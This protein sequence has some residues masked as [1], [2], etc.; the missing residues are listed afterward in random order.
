MVLNDNWWTPYL[1]PQ[2]KIIEKAFKE[3]END[4][5]ITIP[6]DDSVR[7][8]NFNNDSCFGNQFDDINNKLTKLKDNIKDFSFEEQQKLLIYCLDTLGFNNKMFYH[9][10]EKVKDLHRL[11]LNRI[12][13]DLYKFYKLLIEYVNKSIDKET[14][15]KN[16]K[17]DL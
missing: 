10:L 8:I 5:N 6:L 11:L 15:I 12:Y 1:Y 9:D 2:N 4:I 16:I 17:N 13:G 3:Q 7:R 14:L